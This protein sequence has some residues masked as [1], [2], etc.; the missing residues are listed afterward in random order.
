MMCYDEITQSAAFYFGKP[1]S[2]KI[3]IPLALSSDFRTELEELLMR[4]TLW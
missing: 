2:L 3:I 1:G 4:Y